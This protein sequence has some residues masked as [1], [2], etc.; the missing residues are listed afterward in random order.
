MLRDFFDEKVKPL[1]H[2][3]TFVSLNVPRLTTVD[4]N[5]RESKFI[6]VLCPS[7]NDFRTA[8]RLLGLRGP[9]FF[10][11]QKIIF[12]ILRTKHEL[13]MSNE[14]N[15]NLQ[16]VSFIHDSSLLLINYES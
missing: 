12:D 11:D 4:S 3:S 6:V 8:G 7:F 15:E 9:K 1:F 10:R 2:L 5:E 16:N 13:K 14:K